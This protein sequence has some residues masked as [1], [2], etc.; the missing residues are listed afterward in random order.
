MS[1]RDAVFLILGCFS[2]FLLGWCLFSR[3]ART[4]VHRFF[5]LSCGCGFR[6]CLHELAASKAKEREQLLQEVLALLDRLSV[7]AAFVLPEGERMLVNETFARNV[8]FREKG[9]REIQAFEIPVLGE[10]LLQ[11]FSASEP[12]SLPQ[13][14]LLLYPL[15]FGGYR[16]L[17]LEDERKKRQRL[18]NL[19]YFLT[20]LWH[21]LRTPLTVL[22]GYMD[23]LREGMPPEGDV[24]SRMARQ[25]H[26]LDGTIREL[27]KLSGLLEGKKEPIPCETFLSLLYRVCTEQR[28]QRED[29][30][31][32]VHTEC[33]QSDQYLPLSEGEAFVLLANL[34]ANA[35]AFSVPSGEVR[36]AASC[37]ESG[38]S[39]TIEN[40]A[41]LPDMEFLGWFF[42]P[43][44]ALPR[45]GSGKG[46]GL[47]LVREVVEENGGEI[48]LR[49]QGNRVAFE[50]FLPWMGNFPAPR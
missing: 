1:L 3:Y 24:L 45:G 38:L 39:V 31:V 25:I 42:D 44:D 5:G 14:G 43:T 10:A 17:L 37:G 11:A 20:A 23:T 36:I 47:Y 33:G 19:R 7:G 35:F 13:P 22:S 49:T 32:S 16:L 50:L 28:M 15:A 8:G 46:V 4:L 2:G 9:I 41:S 21:E 29:L 48:R 30:T 6:R 27:Q 34:M 40:T 18:H 26:R 12:V